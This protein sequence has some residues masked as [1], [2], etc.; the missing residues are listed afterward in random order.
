[1]W[2]VSWQVTFG[3]PLGVTLSSIFLWDFQCIFQKSKPGDAMVTL[4]HLKQFHL[5]V[6]VGN[7]LGS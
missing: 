2:G 5:E 4:E 6:K 3:T 7:V 1:M